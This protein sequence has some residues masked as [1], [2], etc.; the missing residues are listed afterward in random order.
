MKK[1]FFALATVVSLTLFT[2]SSQA[3]TVESQSEKTSELQTFIVLA[4]PDMNST[5]VQLR[6]EVQGGTITSFS[7]GDD[8][9][10][11]IGVCDEENNK[12][13]ETKVCV[14]IA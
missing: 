7:A 8:G 13:T 1:F 5:A 2:Q 14:D 3:V 10:L 9:L 4:S 6:L 11:S 12:F